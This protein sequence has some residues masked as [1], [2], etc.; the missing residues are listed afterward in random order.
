M[1]V[2]YSLEN[3][4][5]DVSNLSRLYPSAFLFANP[6]MDKAYISISWGSGFR[7]HWG[8]HVGSTNFVDADPESKLWTPGIYFWRQPSG[9]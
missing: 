8:L 2:S 5:A 4:P 7:G 3:L 1:L 9:K 6:S